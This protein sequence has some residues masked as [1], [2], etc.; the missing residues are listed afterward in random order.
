[1]VIVE[2]AEPN[3]HLVRVVRILAG[4]LSGVDILYNVD[5]PGAFAGFWSD[6]ERE[7]GTC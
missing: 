2:V 1:M 6:I 7:T 5:G 3:V 4:S